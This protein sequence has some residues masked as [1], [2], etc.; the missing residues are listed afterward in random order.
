MKRRTHFQAQVS[1]SGVFV[2]SH[3]DFL[4]LPRGV[5]LLKTHIGDTGTKELRSNLDLLLPSSVWPADH[6]A[7]LALCEI[8]RPKAPPVA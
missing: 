2:T 8:E 3:K 4:L 7:V 6:F 5:K 1:K